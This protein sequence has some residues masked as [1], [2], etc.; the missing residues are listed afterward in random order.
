MWDAYQYLIHLHDVMEKQGLVALL[1]EVYRGGAKTLAPPSDCFFLGLSLALPVFIILSRHDARLTRLRNLMAF[2]KSYP[3]SDGARDRSQVGCCRDGGPDPSVEYVR[4]KYLADVGLPRDQRL[5]FQKAQPQEKVAIALQHARIIGH[6]TDVKLI[7]ASLVFVVISHFGFTTL[8]QAF[9]MGLRSAD[10]KLDFTQPCSADVNFKQVQIIGALA[11]AGGYIA[12]IRIFLR[13]LAVFDLSAYT[14]LKQTIELFASVILVVFAYKAAPHPFQS[15]ENMLKPSTDAMLCT[16]IPWYWYALAPTL[17]LLPESSTTFLLTRIEAV[18]NWIKRDDNRFISVTRVIPLDIIEGIDYFTRFRLEECGI[19]DV[20]NLATYNPILL[21]VESPYSIYQCV[22]WIGQ[23]QL[24]H[25]IGLERFLLLR[26][27]HVRTVLDLER[28]IDYGL[29]SSETDNYPCRNH[30][31]SMKCRIPRKEEAQDEYPDEFD[32]IY[33]GILFAATDTM[34]E[35]GRLAGVE[36]LIEKDD[37][38]SAGTIDDYCVW[39][40]NYIKRGNGRSDDRTKACVEHLMGWISDDLH[41]R[42]L[43]RVWQEMSDNLGERSERLANPPR[44]ACEQDCRYCDFDLPR[45]R[46]ADEEQDNGLS[47]GGYGGA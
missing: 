1:A 21:T 16:E 3:S 43:R 28:A 9:S 8:Y 41:V 38:Y 46:R 5:R 45:P 32:V 20:Q 35:V 31:G 33:A 10:M 42:R 23:A 11:F 2:L 44:C 7:L 26:E 47:A 25:I 15:I 22:D 17:A 39:A 30:P 27:M 6:S 34:R 13:G 37:K 36:P 4:A 29:K 14:F 12:A 18:V 24:C 19:R 40:R